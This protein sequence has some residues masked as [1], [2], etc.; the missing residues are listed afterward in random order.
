[1]N[2]WKSRVFASVLAA[3]SLV[4]SGPLSI[5][6][7]QTGNSAP[8]QVMEASVGDIQ[9]AYKSGRLTARQLTQAYLDRISAYNKQGP[10]INAIITLSP[11]ALED[12]DKLDATYRTS[13]FVGPLTAFRFS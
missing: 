5:A 10:M 8:F 12:A 3:T 13:G 1:M 9:A 4:A 6:Q 2:N 7:S 11:N